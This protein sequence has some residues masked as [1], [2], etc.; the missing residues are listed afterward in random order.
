MRS[1]ASASIEGVALGG[2]GG[3][4]LGEA[5]ATIR[6]DRGTRGRPRGSSDVNRF[7]KKKHKK[8]TVLDVVLTSLKRSVYVVLTRENIIARAACRKR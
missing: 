6:R 2:G 3:V 4:P 1:A 7:E 5:D 8:Q